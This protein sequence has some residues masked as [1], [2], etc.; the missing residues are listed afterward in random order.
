MYIG[1][2]T[3]RGLH[4]LIWEIVDNAVDEALAG[5]CRTVVV[6]LLADNV[7]QVT[8]DGRGI[9]V[10]THKETG[11]VRPSTSCSP[12]STAAP[13]S[14]TAATRSP[15]GLHGVGAAVTNALSAVARSGGAVA[16]GTAG[17]SATIMGFP[18]KPGHQGTALKKG[19]GTGTTVRWRFDPPSVFE[20]DVRYSYTAVEARLREKAFLVKGL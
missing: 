13:S 2:I 15:G 10:D 20:S 1:S 6:A 14:A 11:H 17:Q 5:F 8:D 4:H 12:S 7:V 3:S 18:V 16:T 19:A 9:P